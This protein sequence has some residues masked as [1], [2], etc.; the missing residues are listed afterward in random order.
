MEY[1]LLIIT[2]TFEEVSSLVFS[3]LDLVVG[4]DDDFISTGRLIPSDKAVRR[5]Q[6]VARVNDRSVAKL[7]VSSKS[8]KRSCY[9]ISKNRN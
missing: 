9:K 6:N 8:L 2:Y 7:S 5:R 4:A 1:F 3:L